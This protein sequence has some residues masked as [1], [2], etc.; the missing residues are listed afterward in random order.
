G[1]GLNPGRQHILKLAEQADVSKQD[2]E[3]I[4]DRA[5]SAIA[6]WPNHAARGGV[7]QPNIDRIAMSMPQWR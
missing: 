2:A 7:S 4:I 3:H 6:H 1:E 5:Q